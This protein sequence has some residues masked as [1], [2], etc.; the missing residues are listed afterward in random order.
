MDN[1]KSVSR[2]LCPDK[3]S[4]SKYDEIISL[5]K[6]H[7]KDKLIL[8]ILGATATVMS[9]DL[10]TEGFWAVDIGQLDTEY[11]WFLRNVKEK[12]EIPGKTVSELSRYSEYVTDENDPAIKKYFGEIIV[13]IR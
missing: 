8:I 2:I 3:N 13:R 5:A 6:E 4:F 1:A 12:C 11:E 7:G 10:A 9:Y